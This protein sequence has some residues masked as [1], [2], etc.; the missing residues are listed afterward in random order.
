MS[1][2]IHDIVSQ[3]FGE[4]HWPGYPKFEDCKAVY[5]S[6]LLRVV[7]AAHDVFQGQPYVFAL[8]SLMT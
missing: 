8:E 4:E 1:F 2:R 7:L 6:G 5:L 3:F